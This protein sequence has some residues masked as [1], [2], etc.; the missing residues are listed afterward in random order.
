MSKTLIALILAVFVLFLS[1]GPQKM[2][3]E[4]E[5]ANIKAV[6]DEYVASV[7]DEDMD[8]YA[9]VVA[10]DPQMV[11]FGVFGDPILGWDV[12]KKIMVE[13]NAAMSETKIIVSDLAIRI[14]EIG[15]LA[16]ATSLWKLRT[17]MNGNPIELQ[18]RC[19]WILER[20]SEGWVIIHFHKSIAQAE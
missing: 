13:Q 10:H 4:A 2:E 12:L 3:I 19:T 11:N 17:L 20:R 5:K 1:C 8:L 18:I 16:W 6:L 15:K 9:K 14:P 7:E